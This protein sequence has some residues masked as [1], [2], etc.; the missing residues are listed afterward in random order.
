MRHLENVSGEFSLIA[1]AYHLRDA[2]NLVGVPTL[3]EAGVYELG[4][5]GPIWP[6]N[7]HREARVPASN[8]ESE[9]SR[10]ACSRRVDATNLAT[11]ACPVKS[12]DLVSRDIS[13]DLYLLYVT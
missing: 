4:V 8:Q 2:I 7:R 11:T 13:H 12:A 10:A 9:S 3:V 6:S 1:L 5:T